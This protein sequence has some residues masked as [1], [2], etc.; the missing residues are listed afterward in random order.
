MTGPI[1]KVSF[2]T[3][4]IPRCNW[5][6]VVLP[7]EK[8]EK[9]RE[10]CNYVKQYATTNESC[11]QDKR[12]QGKGV[13]VLFSGPSGTGKTRASEV[14]AHELHLDLY[15]IDSSIVVSKYIG[16]TEKNLNRIF[17]DA[18]EGNALL[19]F[20]EADALF[21]KRNKIKNQQNRYATVEVNFLLQKMED[22]R[23]IVILATNSYIAFGEASLRKMNFIVD[24][25]EPVH[26]GKEP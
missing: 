17:K 19:F 9:L 16:E 15:K 11:G 13:S 7:N 23:G 24:F 4:I 20:D 5:D 1:R 26:S 12:S 25:P 22:C 3:K 10:I 2:A 6:T 18:Q 14:I 21:G 8:K